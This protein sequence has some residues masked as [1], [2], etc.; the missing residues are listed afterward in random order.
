MRRVRNLMI[1]LWLAA[2]SAAPA[3]FA[4]HTAYQAPP[5]PA[6][7]LKIPAGSPISGLGTSPT[8]TIT[9]QSAYSTAAKDRLDG[10]VWK[11]AGASATA[12]VP[13]VIMAHG[14][15]GPW[16]NGDTTKVGSQFRRTAEMLLANGIG[17]MLEDSFSV[18]RNNYILARHA[19]D[20]NQAKWAVRPY[21]LNADKAYRDDAVS[22]H[23]VRPYDL[24]GAAKAARAQLPWVD[25]KKLVA[26]GY[27][28]GG[29]AVL[30]L[31]L[32]KYPLNVSTPKQGARL[33]RRL[34]ATYPGC[35]LGGTNSFYANS[36]A[37]VPLMLGTG[38]ADTETPP[39]PSP[40]QS[41]PAGDCRTR[42]DQAVAAVAAATAPPKL[43]VP[44]WFNYVGATHSWEITDGADNDAGRTDWNRRLLAYVVKLK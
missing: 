21:G 2:V 24:A 39:G 14:H 20:P 40:G 42:F 18:A 35:G 28:H 10:W 5:I 37:V 6:K 33:F 34:Y 43:Y 19:G 8:A 36:A 13:L 30:A 25:P 3:S 12:K 38:T 7:V 15:T 17:V 22:D 41:A 1:G 11:P 29:S 16:S 4:G 32:S 27:S 26:I 31:S 9:F 23:L 44:T